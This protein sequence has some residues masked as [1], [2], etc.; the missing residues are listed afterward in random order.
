MLLQS[1]LAGERSQFRQRTR[2]QASV[3]LFASSPPSTEV[4]GYLRKLRFDPPPGWE[5]FTSSRSQGEVHHDGG[6]LSFFPF[7]K[8]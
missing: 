4:G 7:R 6:V 5:A 2:Q 1:D 8:E 3:P